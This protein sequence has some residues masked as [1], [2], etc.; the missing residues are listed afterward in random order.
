MGA[1]VVW[2]WSTLVGLGSARCPEAAQQWTSVATPR[3]A[4]TADPLTEEAPTQA[5][6]ERRT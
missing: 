4:N 5:R 1:A 3:F 2:S 6:G